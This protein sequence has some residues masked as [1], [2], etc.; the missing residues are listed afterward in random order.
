MILVFLFSVYRI[1]LH[2][3]CM[4]FVKG[5]IKH[6]MSFLCFALLLQAQTAKCI[7]INIFWFSSAYSLTFHKS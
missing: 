1:V 7:K 4:I 2:F 3:G 6:S 5:K